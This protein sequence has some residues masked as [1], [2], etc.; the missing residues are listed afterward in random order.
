MRGRFNSIYSH[1]FI[2]AAVCVPSLRVA[3][4]EAYAVLI[5]LGIVQAL[6][7][8]RSFEAF[9]VFGERWRSRVF[10]VAPAS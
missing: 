3:V 1:G 6:F 8:R 4:I 2:R 10:P 7:G 9:T 5:G